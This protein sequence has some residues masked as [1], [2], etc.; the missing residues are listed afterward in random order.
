MKE[1]FSLPKRKFCDG[2]KKMVSMRIP[3]RLWDELDKIAK[4]YGWTTTDLVSTALDEFAQWAK[5]PKK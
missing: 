4:D 5:P 2:P 3:E 1:K